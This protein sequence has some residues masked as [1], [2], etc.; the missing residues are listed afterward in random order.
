VSNQVKVKVRVNGN[1]NGNVNP[2]NMK[3]MK[4]G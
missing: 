4:H 2:A 1:G 3:D